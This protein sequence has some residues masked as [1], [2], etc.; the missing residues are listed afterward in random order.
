MIPPEAEVEDNLSIEE[1]AVEMPESSM[2]VVVVEDIIVL[3][4]PTLVVD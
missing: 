2:A 1:A 3:I 4:C